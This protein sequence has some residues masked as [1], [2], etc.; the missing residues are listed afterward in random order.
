MSQ[1]GV[2][3]CKVGFTHAADDCGGE[4]LPELSSRD[5]DSILRGYMAGG[6]SENL[7]EFMA[8]AEYAH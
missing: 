5:F 2:P 8:A 1:C 6:R 7:E 4:V 3:S